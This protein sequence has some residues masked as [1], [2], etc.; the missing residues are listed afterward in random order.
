[1][2][3][4]DDL[5]AE[6][7]RPG[8][9]VVAVEVPG[10]G[11]ALAWVG[12]ATQVRGATLVESVAA[13]ESLRLRWTWWSAAQAA[14]SLVRAAHH[15]RT[16]WDLAA[17][18]RLAHGG[19]RDDPAAVWAA[20]HGLDEPPRPREALDLLDLDEDD[21]EP[22]RRD[23]QLSRVWAAE[24]FARDLDSGMTWARLG[25]EVQQRQKAAVLALPDPRGGQHR[26]PLPLLMAHAESA[27]AL[28]A[29]ELGHVGLPVDAA[30]AAGIL[31]PVIGPPPR[32]DR[33]ASD[34]RVR[35]D[36]DVLHLF[37]AA[38]GTDLRNP[39]Q[40]RDLLG[41]VGIHVPDTRSWRLEPHA[42]TSPAVAALLA[43]R[44]AERLSTTY[45]WGWLAANVTD[46]RLRGVWSSAEGAGRMTASAG[47]HNLPAELRP[48]VRAEP[49]HVLV[50]ADLGQVE[51]RVLAVVA[52]DEGLAAA[53]R[54]DDM[55][56]P[57]AAQLGCDRP[58]A[59]VAILAAMY[60]QTTGTAGA[61]L[62]R[63][64][65][66]YPAALRFLRAAE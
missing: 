30:A 48:A 66:A 17:V 22:V 23:G 58:T 44:K 4:A 12:G 63:M 11:V 24:G 47:L 54:A 35:R 50:R 33:E 62:R 10:H 64:E 59:K 41:T 3:L 39:A 8:E 13:V 21:A 1:V 26:T 57:V 29:V 31:T 36:R 37:P 7:V 15:V 9:P 61:A 16:C 18:A 6:G 28:L 53:A 52:R 43:W 19:H 51:P 38:A 46:G 14:V 60:G 2:S 56:L 65:R 55:Y 20:T 45:G 25:L 34:A 27:A 42:A 49:G 32:D 5:A 40:V